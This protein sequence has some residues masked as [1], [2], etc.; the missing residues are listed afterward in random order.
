MIRFDAILYMMNSVERESKIIIWL[1]ILGLIVVMIIAVFS[2]VKDREGENFEDQFEDQGEDGTNNDDES[3]NDSEPDPNAFSNSRYGIAFDTKGN[4]VRENPSLGHAT[5]VI[6]C[7][8]LSDSLR[9]SLIQDGNA[10]CYEVMVVFDNGNYLV[11]TTG[12]NAYEDSRESYIGGGQNDADES[13]NDPELHIYPSSKINLPTERI[14]ISAFPTNMQGTRVKYDSGEEYVF[15]EG[16][17]YKGRDKYAIK[18]L[19]D[20]NDEVLEMLGTLELE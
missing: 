14:D 4:E 2:I 12:D 16:V 19:G 10:V 6:D 11:V 17:V 1:A 18:V 13:S 15:Y 3:D 8:K 7:R 5:E 9:N 20:L